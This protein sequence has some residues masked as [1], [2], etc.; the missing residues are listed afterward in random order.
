[1]DAGP[2]L[3]AVNELGRRKVVRGR[4]RHWLLNKPSD[5]VR[6]AERLGS[7]A[8]CGKCVERPGQRR[9]AHRA[10][11]HRAHPPVPPFR[12]ALACRCD[13]PCSTADLEHRPPTGDA[14]E[15]ERVRTAYGPNYDRLC[16]LKRRYDP[17]NLFHLNQNIAP[18]PAIRNQ[19]SAT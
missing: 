5:F 6:N 17:Q 19:L 16:D 14:E 13:E 1:M 3:R 8:E 2:A 15:H 12:L 9:D 4:C 10:N 7:A 11:P 18:E